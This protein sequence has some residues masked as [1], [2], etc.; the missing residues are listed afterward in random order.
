MSVK[1]SISLSAQQDAFARRLVAQG[2]FSSVS[3]VVQNGLD[4]LRQRTEAEEAELAALKAVLTERAQSDFVSGTEMETRVTAM[5]T[6]K[7]RSTRVDG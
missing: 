4:L 1:S 6:A 7:R 3:A 5:I 2:R